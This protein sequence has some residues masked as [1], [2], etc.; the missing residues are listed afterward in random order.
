[1]RRTTTVE[2]ADSATHRTT[3]H[4]TA[5]LCNTLQH[6]R[7][8][9]NK[10]QQSVYLMVRLPGNTRDQ[11]RRSTNSTAHCNTPNHAASHSTTLQQTTTHILSTCWYACQGMRKTTTVESASSEYACK[12]FGHAPFSLPPLS[13]S[14][15]GTHAQKSALQSLYVVDSRYS[16]E[17]AWEEVGHAAFSLPPFCSSWPGTHIPESQLYKSL[18][19]VNTV[20]NSE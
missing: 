15:P 10:L 6:T 4:H 13:G 17:Y 5:P 2:S 20:A 8:H 11:H 12:A 9:C 16:S 7:T 3:L 18:G 19:I 14:L 1:M